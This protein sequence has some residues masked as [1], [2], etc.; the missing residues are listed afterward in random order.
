M[1]PV[2]FAEHYVAG[3][4]HQ[5]GGRFAFV[6]DGECVAGFVEAQ[7][8]DEAEAIEVLAVGH[9]GVEAVAH[10]VVDL[11]DVDWAG[12]D[13]AEQAVRRRRH[14]SANQVGDRLRVELPIA[15]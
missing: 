10:Q 8:A 12:K 13:A 4:D 9:A 6:G 3:E 2:D 15:L 5:L 14:V 11:V 7:A 1:V